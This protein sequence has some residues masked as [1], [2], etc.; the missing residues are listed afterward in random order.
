MRSIPVVFAAA[1]FAG[2]LFQTSAFGQAEVA[3]MWVA[4]YHEDQ[5]ERIPGPELSDYLGLPINDA[6]RLCGEA[7]S[8]SILTLPEFQCRP[9]PSDYGDRHSHVRITIELNQQTQEPIAVRTH[10]EWQAQERMIWLDN[11]PHP[12][13]YAAHTWQGFS[14]GTWDGYDTLTVYTTHLKESY[15]RRNGLPRSDR[16]SVIEHFIRHGQYLTIATIINDPVYLT[17]PLIKSSDYLLDPSHVMPAYPCDYVTEVVREKGVVPSYLPGQNPFLTEFAER[18]HL[19]L[20][21]TQGGAQT[22]YP[23]FRNKM[24]AEAAKAGLSTKK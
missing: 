13:D 7:Y 15:I 20:M 10:R 23:E 14:T 21:A 5:P 12:P 1:L 2:V 9:H 22:M 8:S 19:P 4:Q 24:K 3:G 17:E 18:H 11:R 16:S 6:A